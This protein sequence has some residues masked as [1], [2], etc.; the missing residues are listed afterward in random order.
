[1]HSRCL[2]PRAG[3]QPAGCCL[4]VADLV[5][6]VDLGEIVRGFGIIEPNNSSD[7][8]A[9][10]GGDQKLRLVYQ[11]V[12]HSQFARYRGD[13]TLTAPLSTCAF[14]YLRL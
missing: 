7:I 11:A 10:L 12:P 13:F 8:G 9:T 1:M 5:E 6:V 2:S 14:E 4:P 3:A